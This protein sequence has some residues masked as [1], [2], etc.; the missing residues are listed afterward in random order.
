VPSAQLPLLS[1]GDMTRPPRARGRSAALAA[2]AAALLLLAGCG[3]GRGR[4]VSDAAPNQQALVALL[5]LA[6]CIRAHGLPNFP[7]PQLHANGVPAFPDSAP[8]VPPQTQRACAAIANRIPPAYAVTTAVSESDFAK[9]LQ[10]ARCIRAH[11]VPD[12]PDPNT[13]GAFPIDQRLQQGGKPL[14][15]SAVQA[16]ARLNPNPDGG[17]SVVRG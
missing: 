15:S 11:G 10:L 17:I 1:F 14:I 7:D 6:R 4:P 2:G 8:R 12:W 16:C 13:L 3:A 5:D 9:L